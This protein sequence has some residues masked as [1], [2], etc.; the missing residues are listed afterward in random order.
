MDKIVI[1]HFHIS[2]DYYD[3]H[4]NPSVTIGQGQSPT[5]P[6]TDEAC[7]EDVTLVTPPSADTILF[8]F[9]HPSIIADIDKRRVHDE[10]QNLVTQ[11]P[12]PEICRYLRQMRKG[13]R[14]YLN[15]KPEIMF[16][17]LHRMGM[18]DESV[19]GFSYKNFMSYF[20]I[21]D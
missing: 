13:N 3:I 17:E 1:N 14:V 5:S 11:F 20:N 9:I 21:N 10:I 6:T 4:D 15:V 7:I 16:A 8:K 19:T 12:L 18:P 2:G